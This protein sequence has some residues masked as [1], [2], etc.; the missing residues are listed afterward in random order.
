MFQEFI[1]AYLGVHQNERSFVYL[2]KYFNASLKIVQMVY[3][4]NFSIV[5][6]LLQLLGEDNQASKRNLRVYSSAQ[7]N[8]LCLAVKS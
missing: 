8:A 2:I 4:I 6:F 7:E 3:L 1:C 5:V